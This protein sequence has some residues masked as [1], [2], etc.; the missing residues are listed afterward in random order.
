MKYYLLPVI[1]LILLVAC[2]RTINDEYVLS[3][4]D[5]FEPGGAQSTWFKD[6]FYQGELITTIEQ[7]AGHSVQLTYENENLITY[8]HNLTGVSFSTTSLEIKYSATGRPERM[9]S[10]SRNAGGQLSTRDT[11]LYTWEGSRLVNAKV[12]GYEQTGTLIMNEQLNYSYTGDNITKCVFEGSYYGSAWKDSIEFD[13]DASLNK[14]SEKGLSFYLD[15]F[16]FIN[17]MHDAKMRLL[18]TGVPIDETIYRSLDPAFFPVIQ[19]QNTVVS[20]RTLGGSVQSRF[21]YINGT[22]TLS[23]RITEIRINDRLAARYAYRKL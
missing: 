3:R 2:T 22:G 9:I 5:Y 20:M 23:D 7:V 14:F 1:F 15:E 19:S 17:L 13:Y 12:T 6:L 21:T 4:A 11:V 16:R 10:I 8:D 18:S